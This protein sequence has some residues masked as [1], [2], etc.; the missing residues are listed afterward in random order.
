MA[1]VLIVDD[2]PAELRMLCRVVERS[3]HRAI[4]AS[5][6]AAGVLAYAT[7]RPDWVITDH[8]MP[9]KD[10]VALIREIR[11]V[12]P[13]AQIIAATGQSSERSLDEAI[14]AGAIATLRKP[15]EITQVVELLAEL[16][17]AAEPR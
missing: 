12:F 3:G 14:R 10:G 6:G 9:E 1:L 7:H 8:A 5:D 16:D 13:T 17:R 4:T 15:F 2:E 11:S